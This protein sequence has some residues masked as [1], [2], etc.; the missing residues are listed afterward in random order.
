MHLLKDT[1]KV[2]NCFSV[3]VDMEQAIEVL[4]DHTRFDIIVLEKNLYF[5]LDEG[6]REML[7]SLVDRRR[8]LSI[9]IEPDCEYQVEEVMDSSWYHNVLFPFPSAAQLRSEFGASSDTYAKMLSGLDEPRASNQP[10]TEKNFNIMIVCSSKSVSKL[11]NKQLSVVISE[12][13]AMCS[14][15]EYDA[16][17]ISL[18]KCCTSKLKSPYD[19]IIIDNA[20]KLSDIQT[21]ELLEFLRNQPTTK[22]SLIIS[23]TKSVITNTSALMDAG[24][25]VIWSKPLPEK[26]D[27][28]KRIE[29]LCKHK[30]LSL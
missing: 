9:M 20:L 25:D 27:L 4:Q 3:A 29:R 15:D 17:L 23:L 12:M 28:K 5:T 14:I 16:A 6:G 22:N 8:R 13:N 21:C 18:D 2:D 10:S 1:F 26:E 30:F 11:M 24:A 19:I 7:R